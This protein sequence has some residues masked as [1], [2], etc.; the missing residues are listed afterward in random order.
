MGL[1]NLIDESESTETSYSGREERPEIEEVTVP[2]KVWRYFLGST[3]CHFPVYEDEMEIWEVEAVYNL[4]DDELNSKRPFG[5]KPSELP[6]KHMERY[7]D[8]LKENLEEMKS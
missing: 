1:D 7:R 8:K 6:I 3:K 2:E 4:V 5:R